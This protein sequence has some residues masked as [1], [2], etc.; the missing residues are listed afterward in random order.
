LPGGY[1]LTGLNPK[2]AG[3]GLMLF[4]AHGDDVARVFVSPSVG[5]DT[6]FSKV[7][8]G[9]RELLTARKRALLIAIENGPTEAGDCEAWAQEFA[10]P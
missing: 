2:G 10:S 7:K 5:P 3:D 6:S 9:G 1:R 8:M 4:Y